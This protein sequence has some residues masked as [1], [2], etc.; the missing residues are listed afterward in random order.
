MIFLD[1]DTAKKGQLE[2]VDPQVSVKPWGSTIW[3]VNLVT[4]QCIFLFGV[5]KQ[6]GRATSRS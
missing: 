3:K 4:I 1:L 6:I 5:G 2:A